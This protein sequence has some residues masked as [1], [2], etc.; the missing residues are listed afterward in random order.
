[1]P[2]A[3]EQGAAENLFPPS[4]PSPPDSILSLEDRASY[5]IK[6]VWE[7]YDSLTVGLFEE[8][9]TLENFIKEYFSIGYCLCIGRDIESFRSSVS[10]CPSWAVRGYDAEQ[11]IR[12][13]QLYY[14]QTL[15]TIYVLNREKTVLQRNIK[16][17]ELECWLQD[18]I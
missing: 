18:N 11:T 9:E 4:F 13:N 12:E 2:A 16:V 6:N 8:R 17:A 3:K 10:Q 7:P 14:I 1:M 15:P 5:V